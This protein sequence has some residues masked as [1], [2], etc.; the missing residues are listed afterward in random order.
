MV[1]VRGFYV[2]LITKVGVDNRCIMH[3]RNWKH[4]ILVGKPETNRP[5]GKSRHR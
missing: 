3:G 2:Q 4:N 1:N 5:G